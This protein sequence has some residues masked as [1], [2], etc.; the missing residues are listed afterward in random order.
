MSFPPVCKWPQNQTDPW[1]PDHFSDFEFRSKATALILAQIYKPLVF[2]FLFFFSN[3]AETFDFVAIGKAGNNFAQGYTSLQYK[4]LVCFL[5]CLTLYS[6]AE[7]TWPSGPRYLYTI[8]VGFLLF[9]CFVRLGESDG[10]YLFCEK[11]VKRWLSVTLV[12]FHR[13]CFQNKKIK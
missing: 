7:V 13:P 5:L 4:L 8:S 9:F 11:W 12:L 6:K 10:F 3:F 1:K 2:F